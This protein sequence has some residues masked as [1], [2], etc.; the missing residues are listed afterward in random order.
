MPKPGKNDVVAH[1]HKLV[2]NYNTSA[3]EFYA[4]VG[5]ALKRREV[6][7][8]KTSQVRWSE[9]GLLAPDRKYLRVTGDRHIFDICAA[10]FGTGFFFS[11]WV[12][13]RRPSLVAGALVLL[14][15]ATGILSRIIMLVLSALGPGLPLSQELQLIF[16]NPWTLGIVVPIV[17]FLLC[18]TFV[19][20]M[21]RGGN[22]VAE[23]SVMEIPFI[24]ALYRAFLYTESYYRIDTVLMF[25]SAV[26]T[27][28]LEVIDDLMTQK[29]LRALGDDERK[30]IFRQL[31]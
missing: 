20:L 19:S 27:A 11:S 10:P 17:S 29:G 23:L 22:N 31:M 5:E 2:E 9:G 8:L 26:H 16:F 12:T 24:G 15:I 1:W 14:A 6:P 21:A 3:V 25:Q 4:A 7:G 18:L 30:P 28:M 13:A